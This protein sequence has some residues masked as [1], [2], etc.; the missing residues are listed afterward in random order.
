M[1][2]FLYPSEKKIIKLLS[3]RLSKGELL[4]LINDRRTSSKIN[5]HNFTKS[6][7]DIGVIFHAKSLSKE[8]KDKISKAHRGKKKPN[9]LKGGAISEAHKK[10][11]SETR[12]SKIASGEIVYTKRSDKVKKKI[13]DSLKKYHAA[14]KV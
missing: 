7:K 8:H 10:K 2:N 5:E 1:S 13:S 4:K 14:S 6:C 3:Y 12:L 9:K 11:I